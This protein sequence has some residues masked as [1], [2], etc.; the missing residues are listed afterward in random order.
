MEPADPFR[1]FFLTTI[2]SIVRQDPNASSLLQLL[3][4]VAPSLTVDQI[5]DSVDRNKA[6]KLLKLRIHPDKHLSDLNQATKLFQDVQEFFHRCCRQIEHGGAI[7]ETSSSVQ[8]R[9]RKSK[10]GDD[11]DDNAGVFPEE[12]RSSSGLI[13]YSVNFTVFE[14]WKCM[15]TDSPSKPLNKDLTK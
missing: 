11:T 13:Q 6:F 1:Q 14:K 12:K 7:A 3:Q 9:K 10:T 5:S 4:T 2:Q 8:N 15:T